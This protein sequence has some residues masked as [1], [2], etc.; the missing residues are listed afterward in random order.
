MAPGSKIRVS[1]EDTKWIID[2][3]KPDDIL[4]NASWRKNRIIARKNSLAKYK[5]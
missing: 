4:S 3:P 2:H 1:R 5:E